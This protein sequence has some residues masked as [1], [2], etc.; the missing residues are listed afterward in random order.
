MPGP[1]INL[2]SLVTSLNI[3]MSGIAGSQADA[4]REGTVLGER[5]GDA[6]RRRL[7]VAVESLPDIEVDAD[8]S[9]A[10][11]DI[12]DLRARLAALADKRIGVDISNA[13]AIRETEELQLHLQRLTVTHPD[14]EVTADIS[15][16]VAALA[17]VTAAA[18]QVDQL[19]PTIEVHVDEDRQ[20][21]RASR[22]LS[23]LSRAA[24]GAIGSLASFA[25]QAGRAVGALGAIIPVAAGAA[26]AIASIAPAAA[27]AATASASI[28]LAAGAAKLGLSG[29]GDTL[30]AA[31]APATGAAGGAAQATNAYADAQR[32]LASTIEST[33]DANARA[34]RSV[35]DAE[36][37]LADAQKDALRAQ[38]DINDARQEAARD[39]EDQNSRLI[40]AGLSQRDAVLRVTEAKERL[41]QANENPGATDRQR[42]QAQLAYEQAVQR[43]NEQ[44]VQ[45]RRLQA[46][47]EAANAA[48]VDGSEKVIAAQDRAVLAQR[49]AADQ[50][51]NLSDA[52]AD[53][54]RTTRDGE[55]A[56]RRANEAL[57]QAGQSA[58][59]GAGGVDRFAEA[60]AKLAPAAQAFVREVIALG[61]A[62]N[63]LKL[64]VQQHF[65]A[66]LADS[67]RVTAASVLPVLRQGLTQAA[68]SL[69][70]MGKGVASAAV[71]LSESG[72]LGRALASANTGL[73]NLAGVPGQAVTA[74][75]QLAAAA[76]PSFE[77]LTQAAA[78]GLTGVAAKLSGAF[79]SGGL[80]RAIDG[81]VQQLGVL[82]DVIGNVGRIFGSVFGA[83]QQEGGSFLDTL[84]KI[85]GSIA[86]A[87][88]S[89][90]VQAGL[91]ALFATMA[92]LASTAA[93]LL[94]QALQVVGTT[95]TALAPG[96]QALIVALGTGLQ[97]LIGALGPVLL[98]AAKAVSA[99]AVAASP[100]LVLVGTLASQLLPVLLP[101]LSGLETIFVQLQPVT[102]ALATALQAALGPILAQLPA[103]ITPFV[104]RV[105]VMTEVLL[106]VLTQLI[107]ELP[108]AQLGQSFAEVAA[109]LAPLLAQ[110]TVLFAQFLRVM[111]PLLTPIIQAVAGLATIFAGELA[112]VVSDV[113]V[114]ALRALTQLMNG[115]LRGAFDSGKEATRG[116][117]EHLLRVF[118]ELPAQI[119]RALGD[120][121][122]TL[123]RAGNDLIIGLILGIKNKI[124]DLGNVLGNIT[125]FITEHKGPPAKDATLLTPAGQLLMGGLMQGVASRLPALRAQ[126]QAI[127]AE[128]SQLSMGGPSLALA[129]NQGALTG[130]YAGLGRPVH[131]SNTIN[132]YGSGATASEVSNELSWKAKVGIR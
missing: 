45:V 32:N 25:A 86:D 119:L 92:A 63:S 42:A 1:Q 10:D 103:L 129:S 52:Q 114:P 71:G 67:L 74:F 56:V 62:W 85:T 82:F 87:F 24:S 7:Q 53:V 14:I 65:F 16:A 2:P 111:V 75:G 22:D 35:G 33:A 6:M 66:G 98:G 68:D 21:D 91:H 8:T 76:G 122:L 36:R 73:R 128:I 27:L 69:N 94:G 28:G 44:N 113:V 13:D 107:T 79:A 17:Q 104:D 77:R 81:A 127:T 26:G 41:D 89:P 120:L 12:A 9:E 39:L 60:M 116:W 4:T 108:L 121:G 5:L 29:I 96:A 3:D 43:L 59:G 90:A 46:T 125:D 15:E 112:R 58:G 117:A 131:Q 97:P 23:G 126:L 80:E 78:S 47:T 55:E 51:R 123:F 99:L 50:A 70:A 40:D 124:P 18:R 118:I 101:V 34:V 61:P 102:L 105:T 106:P 54:V 132:M 31:F 84:K 93:P 95:L 100:L 88:A 49:R 72:V 30:K 109:A 38:Q 19:D 110:L 130:A 57:A 115:D 11:R 48:G 20:A 64:D 83:A 37:D